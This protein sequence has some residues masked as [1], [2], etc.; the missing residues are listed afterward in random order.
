MLLIV[1]SCNP[2]APTLDES[3][4][5]NKGLISDQSSVQGVFQ[6]FQ[7][8]YTFKDTL[9]YSNLL[10]KNFIFGYRDYDLGVDVSWSKEEEMRVTNGLFQNT[11]RLDLTW[12]NIISMTSDSTHIIRSFNLTITFNPTDIIFVDGKVNLKLSKEN[13]GKWKIINWIDESNY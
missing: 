4:D 8:A 11:Q 5:S 1:T 3:I 13:D 9:I 10:N 6:N 12:N 2:F 7:Y